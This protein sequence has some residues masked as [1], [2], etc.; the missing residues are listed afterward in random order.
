ML[1]TLARGYTYLEIA[2]GLGISLGTV[3]SHIKNCY[4][5]LTVHS[6]VAAVTRAAE[7]GLLQPVSGK[8]PVG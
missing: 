4:R 5:K 8:K 6:G 1:N 7:L 2:D 3:T